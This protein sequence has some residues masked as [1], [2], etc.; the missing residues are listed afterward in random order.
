MD[1]GRESDIDGVLV[2]FNAHFAGG[3]EHRLSRFGFCRGRGRVGVGCVGGVRVRVRVRVRVSE[4]VCDVSER[5][6]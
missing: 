5:V 1:N 6:I 2:E 3:V 4:M